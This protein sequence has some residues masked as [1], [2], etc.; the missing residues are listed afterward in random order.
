MEEL[1]K[2]KT[3]ASRY[4]VLVVDDDPDILASL[5][6]TLRY[7]FKEVLCAT[8]AEEGLN[9]FSQYYQKNGK[10]IDVIISD[11]ALPQTSGLEMIQMIKKEHPKQSFI[12]SSGHQDTDYFLQAIELG[13]DSF[14]LKPISSTKLAFALEKSLARQEMERLECERTKLLAHAKENAERTAKEQ[15]VFI[16]NAIHEMN[17]PLSVILT[18]ADLIRIKYGGNEFLEQ[19]DAAVKML[20]TSYEDMAYT[21]RKERANFQPETVNLSKALT[22]R[23]LSFIPIAK[24]NA[25]ALEYTI[26]PEISLAC[27]WLKF[28]RIIDNSLSNAI[29]YSYRKTT[30]R[31]ELEETQRGYELSFHNFGKVIHDTT[32]IWKRFYRENENRGGYGLGLHIVGEICKEDNI[33]VNVISDEKQGTTFTYIIPKGDNE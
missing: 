7:L 19:I 11:I 31:V 2:L 3:T 29:K 20:Q 21:I 17:T 27:V 6:E 24:A 4:T 22:N 30:I 10:A 25:L 28:V 26:A 18:N 12:I 9:L 5:T 14:L 15:D 23:V 8:H 16:K 13:V 33:D 32:S 1:L